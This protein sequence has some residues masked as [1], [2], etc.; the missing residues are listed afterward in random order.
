MSQSARSDPCSL[1]SDDGGGFLDLEDSAGQS[2]PLASEPEPEA[3]ADADDADPFG[4]LDIAAST[5]ESDSSLIGPL[6]EVPVSGSQPEEPR[7]SPE[8]VRRR[9]EELERYEADALDQPP[10]Y[11]SRT[12]EEGSAESSQDFL[13]LD[14]DANAG[15]EGSKDSMDVLDVA[16]SATDHG[17]GSSSG[18][19]VSADDAQM[20]PME[21]VN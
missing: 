7:P 8:E 17:P 19:N 6:V 16:I 15:D 9:T 3:L 14:A 20:V 13:D 18:Q 4:L 10:E 21:Q 1:S 5:S 2:G 12:H 11:F